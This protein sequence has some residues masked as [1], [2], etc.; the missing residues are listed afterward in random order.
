MTREEFLRRLEDAL[1]GTLSPGAVQENL[2]YYNQYILDEIRRGKTEEEVLEVLGDPW[3]IART[4]IDAS[5]GTDSSVAY[6]GVYEDA[7]TQRSGGTQGTGGQGQERQGN[8]AFHVFGF[9]TWWKKFLLVLCILLFF[10][11]V[12][13]VAMGIFRL[14]APLVIP[15]VVILIVIRLISGNRR[16]GPR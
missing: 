1:R 8:N 10:V 14:L 16:G 3:A 9:D 13:A 4:I 5:D 11:V 7:Y 12:I 15:V 2:N 6:D